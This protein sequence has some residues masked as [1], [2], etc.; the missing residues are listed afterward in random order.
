[1]YSQVVSVRQ[2]YLS[3]YRLTLFIYLDMYF[4][5]NMRCLI[6]DWLGRNAILRV[7][8]FPGSGGENEGRSQEFG[9]GDT[10]VSL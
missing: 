10:N 5:Q 9:E 1:M 2:D 4:S 8:L 3:W 7:L 6:L